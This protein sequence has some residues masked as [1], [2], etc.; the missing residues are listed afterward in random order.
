MTP[1]KCVGSC[2]RTIVDV[3]IENTT[4]LWSDPKSWDYDNII[5]HVPL[6][7][8]DVEIIPGWNMIYD[9]LDSPLINKLEIN[10]RLTFQ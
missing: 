6:E 7:N 10:G 3:P 4:R 2:I 1:L 8:E 5:G 9:L